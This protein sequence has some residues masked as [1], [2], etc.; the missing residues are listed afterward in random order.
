MG[1]SLR[2]VEWMRSI[3]HDVKHLRDE[4]LQ[5]LS[6]EDIFSRADAEDRIVLTFDLDFGEIV[7]AGKR[8][9]PSVVIFRLRDA[10]S[11]F[12]VKRLEMVFA[13]SLIDL[14]TGAVIVVEDAR[15]RV[16]RL[17]FGD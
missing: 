12:V 11:P 14:Q 1:V 9:R 3:G 7:A 8:S 5:R 2:V 6:D 16:R 10:T 15:H 17:P 4:G 13:E